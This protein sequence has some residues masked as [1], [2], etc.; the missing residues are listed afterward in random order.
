MVEIILAIFGLIMSAYFTA[1][2]IAYVI[3]EKSTIASRYYGE[4]K[5][6]LIDPHR[7][8]TTVLIGTNLSNVL[9]AVTLTEFLIRR[10]PE[11]VAILYAGSITT[12][13]VLLLGE[14]F[15]KV[16][17]R[18][19]PE[20]VFKYFT[21]PLF[22]F[23]I[24]VRWLIIP[25]DMFI[26]RPLRRKYKRD[27]IRE[28]EE[29]IWRGHRIRGD[30]SLREFLVLSKVLTLLEKKAKDIMIPIRDIF[31]LP[32]NT[33]V[34][35]AL[36]EPMAVAEEKFPIFAEKFDNITGIVHIKDLFGYEGKKATV[37]KFKRK[38]GFVY[39]DWDLDRV[40]N[41]MGE[42]G[43]SH[44]VVVDEFGNCVG[45]ISLEKIIKELVYD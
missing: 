21:I 20:F 4:V 32:E 1:Y 38:I 12:I 35:D 14:I 40:L 39:D 23:Y 22:R 31:A 42:K 2:E 19:N 17:G 28:I 43:V 7:V 30:L 3:R 24:G 27:I 8:I 5:A 13:S 36:R 6:F 16:M 26:T 11:N 37:K 45:L 9:V 41:H 18:A 15:P 10:L 33:L 34:T 44:T 25:F 29:I